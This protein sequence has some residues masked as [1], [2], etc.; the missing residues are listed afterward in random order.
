MA[1]PLI[2]I[3]TYREAA[4]WGTWTG[5]RPRAAGGLCGVG[6]G[7]RRYPAVDSAARP[8]RRRRRRSSHRLDGLVLAGGADVNPSRYSQEPR[9][10]DH[11]LAGRSGRVRDGPAD[12]RR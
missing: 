10:G 5:G 7:R 12:R 11:Q 8:R 6:P 3:T 9:P 4:A 1:R 2:G